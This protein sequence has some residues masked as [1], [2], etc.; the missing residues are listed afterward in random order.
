VNLLTLRNISAFKF[1]ATKFNATLN[2]SAFKFHAT[3][4][5]ATLNISAFK[6][7]ATFGSTLRCEPKMV[8]S[9][10]RCATKLVMSKL[11]ELNSLE[12]KPRIISAKMDK[13]MNI[14]IRSLN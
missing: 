8:K 14:E 7:H 5:N 3:K 6:F 13:C 11:T 9:T 12:I 1:H 4:F 2:I 10:L